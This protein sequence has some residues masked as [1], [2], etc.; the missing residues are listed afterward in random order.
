MQWYADNNVHLNP[1]EHLR[2]E[3][4][5]RVRARQA[6]PKSIAQLMEL[7]QR[8]MATD[9]RGC[10][11]DTRREH[12]RQ[13]GCC[14]SRKRWPYEIL[15]DRR[16][17][18]REVDNGRE[19][20][21]CECQAVKSVLLAG[22]T[23]EL[24]D[25]NLLASQLSEPGSIPG[26]FGHR[27]SHV[28]IS[29]GGAA[30]RPVFSGI[31]RF[32]HLCFPPL[33]HT[34]LT[35]PS[36]ALKTSINFQKD[37]FP[38]PHTVL[39]L[40][41]AWVQTDLYGTQ[42][43][44][45]ASPR[46][47][48][49][50]SALAGEKV[51]SPLPGVRSGVQHVLTLIHFPAALAGAAVVVVVRLLPSHL[52][53]LGS[54]S[55]GIA[56]GFSLVAIVPDDN[57]GLRVFSVISHFPPP[58]SCTAPLTPRFTLIG[59]QDL[60]RCNERV[61]EMGD[62][63]ENP[64]TNGIVRHDSHMRKSGMTRPG[65]ETESPWW[66][67]SRLTAQPHMSTG[68]LAANHVP[69]S[70]FHVPV[71]R[72][73]RTLVPRDDLFPGIKGRDTTR[74]GKKLL[75]A[76]DNKHQRRI[77]KRSSSGVV[78]LGFLHTGNIADFADVCDTPVIESLLIRRALH[79]AEGTV[80]MINNLSVLDTRAEVGIRVYHILSL[81]FPV[82][83]RVVQSGT[84]VRREL[85]FPHSCRVLLVCIHTRGYL[86]VVTSVDATVERAQTK[87][88]RTHPV[89]GAARCLMLP[90]GIF[91]GRCGARSKWLR[92]Q[93]RRMCNYRHPPF[94]FGVNYRTGK[95]GGG[96]R[97]S[98][99]NNNNTVSFRLACGVE[100]RRNARAGKREIPGGKKTGRWKIASETELVGNYELGEKD[101]N[102]INNINS[103][104]QDKSDTERMT[105]LP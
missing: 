93:P 13:G 66:E 46:I 105:K 84:P 20:C 19:V 95:R 61:W 85:Y 35:S 5:R 26:R 53:Q 64:P 81:W 41:K 91:F 76:A 99:S 60:T 1:R 50:Q 29:P 36:L 31:S 73:V 10:P 44:D 69:P 80:K 54:I 70:T 39:G 3:L 30:V 12:D 37:T 92:C 21:D 90:L 56:P 78:V 63:R 77:W 55:S 67:A 33:L 40:T 104:R 34:R 79:E 62:P 100:Q 71:L 43:I 49:G 48:I 45:R 68:L 59:S 25:H 96:G 57:T 22:W 24:H 14:Y 102:D 7:L 16:R 4:D 65:I 27:F 17:A 2:Y 94:F 83:G 6:R 88:S 47:Y 38:P 52:G 18:A 9:P 15:T 86:K 75:R 11:A 74:D 51:T 58:H 98:S 82:D 87:Q 101:T 42:I 8:G 89:G 97:R 103:A 28:R 72:V 32:S 23:I